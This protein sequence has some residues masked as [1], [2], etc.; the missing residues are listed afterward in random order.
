MLDSMAAAQIHPHQNGPSGDRTLSPLASGAAQR[1][2]A[3]AALVP[4]SPWFRAFPATPD[5]VG[6][7]RRFL[8]DLLNGHP[9]TDNAVL[10]VSELA[11]NSV[12][13]SRS[14]RTGGTFTVRMRRRGPAIRIEVTDEGGSFLSRPDDPEHGRG[15][16]VVDE[17]SDRHGAITIGP[18]DDPCQRTAWFEIRPR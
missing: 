2:P 4:S 18:P 5:Q 9:A 13:H 6:A 17:L 14:A 3:T 15:L 7:A 11:G 10:C 16:H 1:E 8:A 12:R